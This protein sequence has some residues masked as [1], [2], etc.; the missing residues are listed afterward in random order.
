MRALRLAVSLILLTAAVVGGPT[1]PSARRVASRVVDVGTFSPVAASAPMSSVKAPSPI[2][3]ASWGVGRVDVFFRGMADTLEQATYVAGRGWSRASLGGAVTSGPAVVAPTPG[4]V[5]VFARGGDGAVWTKRF[6]AGRWSGWSSLGGSVVGEPSAVATGTGRLDLFARFPDDTIHQRTWRDGAWSGWSPVA[7]PV[8]SPPAAATTGGG[9]VTVFAR[10]VDDA[11]WQTTHDGTAWSPLARVGGTATSSPTAVSQPDGAVDLY[12]R[13]S[14]GALYH[15]AL[16][17]GRYTGWTGLGGSLASG[18]AGTSW[19]PGHRVV[20]VLGTDGRVYHRSFSAG[21]W[22]AFA[23]A[24]FGGVSRSFEEPLARGVT[25]RSI[26]DPSGPFAIQVVSVDL[27]APSTLDTA[28]GTSELAGLETT[29]SIA[30]RHDALVAINGDFA[31]SSGR[32]VH[33][34]AEDGRLLQ[35]EQTAGRSFAVDAA[36]TTA[37]VGFPKQTISVARGDGAV[38]PIAKVNAGGPGFDDVIEFTKEGGALEQPSGNGCSARLRVLDLPSL[39]AA[40]QAR[41]QQMV[42]HVQCDGTPL[43]FG[44]GDVLSAAAGGSKEAFIRSLTPGEQLL[45]RWSLGWPGVKD[46]LGGNPDLLSNGAITPS[47]DGTGAFFSRNPRTAVAAGPGKVHLV[48]V[49]GRQPGYSVGM[50]L[51]ELARFLRTLGA[52]DALNLD[53]G[54]SSTMVING[55]VT[56]RPS[57]ATERGVANALLVL[58]G[59]D[60]GEQGGPVATTQRAGAPGAGTRSAYDARMTD[61]ASTGGYADMLRRRGLM[62]TAELDRAAAEYAAR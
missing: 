6:Y 11:V 45:H 42:E 43:P 2:A 35:S 16:V 30:T 24:P 27:T 9:H 28:L 60:P 4:L 25:F 33:A 59:A 23:P 46:S 61:P 19:A 3:A 22:S 38:Q 37:Y 41:Q 10:G 58:R 20:F 51:R 57:D 21:R 40:G 7:G 62:I 48:V 56:N 5:H 13:G 36:E 34:Y 55:A 49:D 8:T 44:D 29:S 53:G 18:A 31:M 12:V 52:T 47:V 54:G 17:G 39:D 14:D 26:V 1:P 15:R 32:P 50:T